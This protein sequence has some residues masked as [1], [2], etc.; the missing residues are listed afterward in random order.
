MMAYWPLRT[1]SLPP[2]P[3]AADPS[4]MVN[5]SESERPGLVADA[6]VIVGVLS[7]AAGTLEGGVYCAAAASIVKSVPHAGEHGTPFA[8]SVHVTP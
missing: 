8:V 5:V 3:Q 1:L 4:K 7:G 2:V 6:A